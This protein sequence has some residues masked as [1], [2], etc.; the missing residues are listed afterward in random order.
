MKYASIFLLCIFFLGIIFSGSAYARDDGASAVNTNSIDAATKAEL[1]KLSESACMERLK[2]S[3][4]NVQEAR[5]K[6]E[7]SSLRQVAKPIDAA[8]DFRAMEPE[9]KQKIAELSTELQNKLK[10]MNREQLKKISQM[11]A[12]Q[13]RERLQNY[14]V[15]KIYDSETGYKARK[16]AQE[17]IQALKQ[18]REQLEEK[19]KNLESEMARERNEF[20]KY[21]EFEKGC[22][23]NSSNS[24]EC[25]QYR[26]RAREYAKNALEKM[27]ET[28]LNILDRLAAQA[29]QNED[30]T[31]QELQEIL[32]DI[33]AKKLEIN[34]ALAALDSA[35][36]KDEIKEAGQTIIDLWK[37]IR[38][39]FVVH[40]YRLVKANV[41]GILLR[42]KVL[43]RK[44][45]RLLAYYREK[46]MNTSE[47]QPLVDDYSALVESAREKF[48]QADEKFKEAWNLNKQ[49]NPDVEQIHTL[50]EEGRALVKD[51]QDD[52]KEAADK[53]KELFQSLKQDQRKIV[54]ED[55]EDDYYDIEPPAMPDDDSNG[56]SANQQGSDAQE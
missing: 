46:D 17:K 54:L 21:K 13:I 55:E 52:L 36:T 56:G 42:A 51:A 16:V 23:A 5:L 9:Q 34:D 26:E 25:E 4:P 28:E 7:C 11:T 35:E 18:T 2:S 6:L 15:V 53:I 10:L 33:D 44:L 50:A 8:K 3:F 20:N 47:I 19:Y 29:E 41:G 32:D 14:N 27:A 49:A 48:A 37:E 31:E 40:E 24:T 38:Q 45:D 12:E 22:D 30:L 43:D 39:R 1:A